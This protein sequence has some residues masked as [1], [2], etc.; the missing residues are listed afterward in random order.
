MCRDTSAGKVQFRDISGY[1]SENCIVFRRPSMRM[2]RCIFVLFY[3]SLAYVQ[4]QESGGIIAGK[5]FDEQGQPVV[6]AQVLRGK[7]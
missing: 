7:N 5:V 3:F 2:F 1:G 4:A 6:G